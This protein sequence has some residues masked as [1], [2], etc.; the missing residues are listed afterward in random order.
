[1][2]AWFGFINENCEKSTREVS[3]ASAS[4]RP[5]SSWR[6]C[7][8]TAAP[9]DRSSYLAAAA[10]QFWLQSAQH[11]HHQVCGLVHIVVANASHWFP[12]QVHN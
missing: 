2:S 8:D 10:S 11:L 9:K 12:K 4:S 5:A 7:L 6:A 3:F 1:M